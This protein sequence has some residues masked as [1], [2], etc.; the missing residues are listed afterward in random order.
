MKRGKYMDK[1]LSG[2]VIKHINNSLPETA[3][4]FLN[5]Y[6]IA[7]EGWRRGLN[8][9]M[10]ISYEWSS[11]SRILRFNLSDDNNNSFN[12]N[13][14]APSKMTNAAR[15]ICRNKD[16][17]KEVFNEKGVP[18]AEGKGFSQKDNIDDMLEFAK[19]I[20][21]PVVLK[22]NNGEGGKGV[23]TNI[24]NSSDLRNE[25]KILI[26]N[27]SSDTKIIIEKFYTGNDYRVYV[28]E[29]K[30]I[31]GAIRLP[32]NVLGT[33]QHS[34]KQLIDIKNKE[35][36]K[37]KG[38]SNKKKI[39]I[40]QELLS[41][42]KNKGITLDTILPE[43][44]LLYLKIKC[45][46]SSGGESVDITDELTEEEKKIAISAVKAIDGLH[47]AAVDLLIDK[48]KKTAIVIE[49]NTKPGLDI[50][51]YPTFGKARDIPTEIIDYLFPDTINYD[52]NSSKKMYFD[53]DSVFNLTFKRTVFS[54]VEIPLIPNNIILKK[55]VIELPNNR[56]MNFMG[57]VQR[58]A[59]RY[60]ISGTI[61]R[62]TN[63]VVLVVAGDVK[64]VYEGLALFEDVIRSYNVNYEI[65]E[66]LRTLPV[67]QG[68]ECINKLE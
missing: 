38:P 52:K 58:I 25:I 63:K 33:G 29:D 12:F 49:L 16:L 60:K 64:N 62:H 14:A 24:E 3:S 66:M 55:Y 17:T 41:V 32:A 21:F 47:M 30:V 50:Q 18:Q 9:T 68:F 8:L 20:G 2:Q 36:A 61:K 31:A 42:L 26:E 40:D 37:N 48:D 27:S 35:R 57:R 39:N 44:E 46:V 23:V 15:K 4:N 54:K 22:P 43:G 51:M 67:K 7:L 28:I 34:I 45:N 19:K 59:H 13:S 1:T 10:G 56:I 6:A 11:K 65:K 53:F 5:G